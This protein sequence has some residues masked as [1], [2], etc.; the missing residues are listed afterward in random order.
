[1]TELDLLFIHPPRNF[2][3]LT[4]NLE[5]RSS[6]LT[7]PMGLFSMADLLEREGFNVKI[8]N[9]A[10]E[11]HLNPNFS[12]PKYLER[13]NPKIIGVDLQWALH[14]A[15]AL[16][17][18]KMAKILY[19]SSFTV[20]GGYTATYFAEEIMNA[21]DFIDGIIKSDAEVPIV[22]LAKHIN[23]L[24]KVPNLIYRNNG[25]IYD[26][27]ITYLTENL[28]EL[29]FTNFHFLEHWKQYI[30][31]TYN[32]MHNAWPVEMARGCPFNCVNC[33]GSYATYSRY[34]GRKKTIFR[35]PDKV[36]E[37]IKKVAEISDVNGIYYGHGIYPVTEKYFMEI[38]KLI[39]EEKLDIHADLELWRLP[40]SEKAT[41]DFAKTYDLEKSII[42]F[43]ARSFSESYRKKFHKLYGRLDNSFRFSNSDLDVL[44]NLMNKHKVPLRLFWD[45]GNPQETGIDVLNNFLYAFKLFVKSLSSYNTTSFW[46][47]PIIIT[48]GCPIH[49][50]DHHF[51]I[52]LKTNS[53]KDYVNLSRT[54]KMLF[55]PIDVN[56]NYQTKYLSSFGINMMNKVNSLI[57]ILSIIVS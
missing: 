13:Y 3:F 39:R 4:H 47:E 6:Y 29:N 44:I 48:P 35:S 8:I 33:A 21:Y 30:S 28:D 9:Y 20:L 51:G 22:Q 25:K 12:L 46:T 5:K 26:N 11:K 10:L 54:S 49:H 7:M 16:D 52:D 2:E 53:F 57:N 17:I 37:D 14:S 32:V 38:N 23:S 15:G 42:W 24:D 31:Y 55:P 56:V 19:P 18:I 27:N 40:I 36:V 45:I 1:M 43:S 34:I 50:Y 41:R